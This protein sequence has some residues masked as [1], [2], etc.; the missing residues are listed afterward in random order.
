VRWVELGAL[1]V[2]GGAV[3]LSLVALKIATSVQRALDVFIGHT[4]LAKLARKV[5]M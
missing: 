1:V 3:V 5:R 2:G 4:E